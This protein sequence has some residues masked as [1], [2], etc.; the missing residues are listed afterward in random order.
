MVKFSKILFILFLVITVIFGLEQLS[1]KNNVFADTRAYCCNHI[2]DSQCDGQSCNGTSTVTTFD[3]IG[4]G[5]AEEYTTT[6]RECIDL[7]AAGELCPTGPITAY[8]MDG[9]DCYG[10]CNGH[11]VLSK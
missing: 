6:C 1:F 10:W 5:C 8:C 7:T 2:P 3:P 11:W 4:P 9:D